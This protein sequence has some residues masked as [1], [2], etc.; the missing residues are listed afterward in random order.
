MVLA[1]PATSQNAPQNA[2]SSLAASAPTAVPPLVPYSGAV[3]A[4][5]GRPLPANESVTF[6]I[7]SEEQG[8]EPLFSETQ[9]IAVDTTGHFKAQIGATL[10]NGLPIDLF[11]SGEARWLA[12]QV[13]GELAQPRVL[14]A[15]VPYALKAADAATLGGL[16]ASAF[17]LAGTKSFASSA[18]TPDVTPTA[19]TPV[20]ATGGFAGYLPVFNSASSLVNS[21]VYQN[22]NGIGINGIPYAALDVTGRTIFRGIMV[23]SRAG[24]ATASTGY[25]SVPLQFFANGWN[26]IINGPVQPVMQWQAEVTGNN[27]ASPGATL[28]LLYN[29]GTVANAVETGLYFNPNG[30]IHFAP[31]QTFP[32]GGG[33]GA[34]TGVTAG[35]AL[36][37]GGT[38]GNVTLNLD[39]TKV[40]L[41]G[42]NNIFAGNQSVTGN[43][44]STGAANFDTGGK[45]NIGLSAT[46]VTTGV[47]GQATGTA[48][49]SAGVYGVESATTGQVFGVNGSTNSTTNQAAGVSG[50][51]GATAGQVYGVSGGTTSATNFAAG[52]SGYNFAATGQVFG[53]SGGTASTS[54]QA[55]GVSGS[56]SALTGQVF[57]VTGNTS[58]STNLAAGVQ[59]GENA[60]TGVVY[61]VAGYT[62]SATAQASG[63][64]GYE[65]ALTGQVFGVNGGTNSTTNYAAGV[66]GYEGAATG[67]VF[68]VTGGTT[69]T[70]EGAAG[71]S[72]SANASTGQVYGVSGNTNSTTDYASGVNGYENATTGQVWGVNGGTVSTTTGAAGVNGADYAT[73]G[74]VFGVNGSTSSTT[75]YAAGVSG[76]EGSTTGVVYGVSGS[77]PSTGGYGVAGNATATSGFANGVYGQTA[78]SGGN[79]VFGSN[80]ST[81]GG[82][83]VYGLAN[84]ANGAGTFGMNNGTGFGVSSGNNTSGL[85]VA[86]A[87]S[88][89]L[90]V[91]FHGS[92]GLFSVD[93]DGNGFFAGNLNVTGKVSKGSG[94]FKIDDPLDPA[95]K[96]LSHS[97]VESPDMM[98]VYNG[99]IT[100]DKH[101][102][103]TVE[104]P[105]YF[106][107]LNSDFR[108]QL[109]VMGQFAQAI[110]ATKIGHNRF[111]IRTSKPAVEVSWQVT[112]IR[113]DAYANANRIPTEEDKPADE[114]GYYLHPEVFGEPA[115]KSVVAAHGKPSAPATVAQLAAGSR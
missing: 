50:F 83:G 84:S 56:E 95:N 16:P 36:T 64:R 91:G 38:T 9:S 59:G 5:A 68:G 94:S 21:T 93:S 52:V 27:T 89:D 102:L 78:S 67:V 19:G 115:S 48:T 26:S 14:L 41:L 45:A 1:L 63:V 12:V 10:T 104:L 28:N 54:P 25:G 22:S 66:S 70:T 62:T 112:G 113:K 53:V 57:G 3:A 71:V 111:V 46:G 81:S 106:E 18:L 90:I 76:Y 108:Y 11:A 73:T 42:A 8:G 74:Q 82:W 105:Q 77:T 98:N 30:T 96:Y 40:P 79:G 100:T 85:G 2:A 7:Y 20:T 97:F 60:S 61:G 39:T 35:T 51:E 44:S 65:T 88:T 101:G 37:G 23:V 86:L 6:L 58:S 107:S 13:A 109:T 33:G 31:G 87:G 55:A 110:V 4:V 75:N 29:N 43:I 34:I 114:R 80:G 103:A 99:N 32:G 49:Y 24:N 47:N 17:A 15:S 92:T 72:G 69:S